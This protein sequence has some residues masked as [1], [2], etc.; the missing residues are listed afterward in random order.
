VFAPTALPAIGA[1]NCLSIPSM[2]WLRSGL[3]CAWFIFEPI[4]FRD[5]NICKFAD[6]FAVQAFGIPR[7]AHDK[8][9]ISAVMRTICPNLLSVAAIERLFGTYHINALII[10]SERTVL[11][12]VV[13]FPATD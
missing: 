10:G 5:R 11:A 4:L 1:A 9:I 3:K 6:F 7:G 8:S 13:I 2:H 12:L